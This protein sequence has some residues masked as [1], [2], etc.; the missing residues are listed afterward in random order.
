MGHQTMDVK[1]EGGSL[2]IEFDRVGQQE[3]NNIWLIGPAQFVFS[4]TIEI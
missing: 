4:G 2:Q 1:V 3:F